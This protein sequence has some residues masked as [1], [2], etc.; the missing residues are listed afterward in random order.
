MSPQT[1]LERFLQDL[2]NA[3]KS[4]QTIRAYRSDLSAFITHCPQDFAAIN[5]AHL[6]A[7]FSEHSELKPATRARKRKW[8]NNA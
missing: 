3:N 5:A 1:A 4:P 7:Y 2:Q 8:N 6:R